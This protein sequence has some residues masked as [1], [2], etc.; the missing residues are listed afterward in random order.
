MVGKGEWNSVGLLVDFLG[1]V[2]ACGYSGVRVAA[3]FEE[4]SHFL[5]F[6]VKQR[7]TLVHEFLVSKETVVLRR[8]ERSKQK[9][10]FIKRVDKG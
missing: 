3:F 2:F 9:F 8:W 4:M 6:V 10:G 7:K 1:A 5:A